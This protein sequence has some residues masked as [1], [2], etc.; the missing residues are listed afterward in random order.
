MTE[1]K[2]Q[3]LILTTALAMAAAAHGQSLRVDADT[4]ARMAVDAS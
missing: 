4:A 3:S 2:K 1:F